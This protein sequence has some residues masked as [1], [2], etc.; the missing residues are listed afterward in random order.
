MSSVSFGANIAFIEELY[1][2]FRTDPQSVSPSWRDFFQDY[3]PQLTEEDEDLSQPVAAVAARPTAAP[4]TPVKPSAPAISPTTRKI[5][6]SLSM[7]WPP[8]PV[9]SDPMLQ[10]MV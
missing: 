7:A 1:E 9:S 10:G 5:S 2:K 8:W 6:A 4:A 3:D